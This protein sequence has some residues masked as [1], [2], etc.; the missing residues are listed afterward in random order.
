MISPNFAARPIEARSHGH[1]GRRHLGLVSDVW[2]ATS[3]D[4][5]VILDQHEL[6]CRNGRPGRRQR[7]C[8]ASP[9]AF[10]TVQT[11]RIVGGYVLHIGQY[12]QRKNPCGR[13]QSKPQSHLHVDRTEKNHTGTHLAN[14]ALRETL[15]D[16]VQQKGSLVDP[17]KLRFD[18]SHS[19]SMSEDEIAQRRKTRQRRHRQKA[20]GLRPGGPA[21]D[22]P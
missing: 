5:A 1:L 7:D 14:W 10:S 9:T 16:G 2:S 21:G 6:L 15:G 13:P 19:K 17:E 18:F 4:C 20:S 3:M 22:R 12:A 11:T 8:S